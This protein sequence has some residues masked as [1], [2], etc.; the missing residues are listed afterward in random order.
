MTDHSE[1]LIEQL[2]LCAVLAV[3]H[4]LS[5]RAALRAITINAAKNAGIYDRVG[6]I[7]NDKDADFILLSGEPMSFDAKVMSVTI[8]GEKIF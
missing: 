3:K 6:S 1:I 8:N 2:Y 7:K 5:A 4:G